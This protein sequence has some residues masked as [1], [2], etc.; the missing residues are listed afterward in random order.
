MASVAQ[1]APVYVIAWHCA[2]HQARSGWASRLA[3]RAGEVPQ[4]PGPA[5][6]SAQVACPGGR[7][8]PV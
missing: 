2:H 8:A 5:A 1:R 3:R 4:P 7:Y 6:W